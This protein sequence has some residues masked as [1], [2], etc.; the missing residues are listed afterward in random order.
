MF[1]AVA[2]KS[3]RF[4]DE[5]MSRSGLTRPSDLSRGELWVENPELA[6]REPKRPGHPCGRPEPNATA[7]VIIAAMCRALVIAIAAQA[8]A[9]MVENPLFLLNT[10]GTGTGTTA[11]TV[12]TATATTGTTAPT[13]AGAGSQGWTGSGSAGGTAESNTG[14]DTLDDATTG[15]PGIPSYPDLSS[16]LALRDELKGLGVEPTSGPYEFGS[17]NGAVVVY[18]DMTTDGGGWT[19]VGRSVADGSGDDFGWTSTR[20]DVLDDTQPYALGLH[21]YPISFTEILIGEY[22]VGK[23]WGESL[24]V[25]GAPPDYVNA[26]NGNTT[27]TPYK[28]KIGALGCAPPSIEMLATGGYTFLFNV[29]HFTGKQANCGD[30]PGL[31]VAGFSFYDPDYCAIAIDCPTSGE[32][33]GKQGMLMVR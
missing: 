31:R 1:V 19:L 3:R 25:V 28:R 24:H 8:T 23:T 16:C 22:S 4:V 14:S 6:P 9:C 29:F 15:D 18:C 26:H 30:D 33:H 13:S 20:G 21:L 32:L 12:T 10:T 5:P 17:P 2:D 11:T 27:D 7:D